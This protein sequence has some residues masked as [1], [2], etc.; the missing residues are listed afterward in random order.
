MPE[1]A[2]N[3]PFIIWLGLTLFHSI[4][5]MENP[6]TGYRQQWVQKGNNQCPLT[7]QNFGICQ[8]QLSENAQPKSSLE[9]L[10]TIFFSFRWQRHYSP[11]L[12]SNNA[13]HQLTIP[14][15]MVWMKEQISQLKGNWC[16]LVAWMCF[17]NTP[18][19]YSKMTYWQLNEHNKITGKI[20]HFFFFEKFKNFK[21]SI[22]NN[23]VTFLYLDCPD[24]VLGPF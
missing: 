4:H 15:Q 9:T 21:R 12:E 14:N 23:Y 20:F 13:L 18:Q 11:S 10:I 24:I 8:T 6:D 3:A 16:R 19:V 17:F 22:V 5:Q 7:V 2:K 1:P